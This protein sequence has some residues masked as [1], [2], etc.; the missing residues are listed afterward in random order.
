[1]SVALAM[2][3][4]IREGLRGVTVVRLRGPL[5]TYAGDM[6][7]A[8][9]RRRHGRRGAARARARAAR[10]EGL[11]PRRARPRAPAHRTVRQRR[12]RQRGARS[13]P[14]TASTSCRPSL[15]DRMTELLVGTKKGLFALRGRA[16]LAVRGGRAGVRRRAGRVRDARPAHGRGDRVGHLAVLRAEALGRRRRRRRVGAGR[17]GCRCPRAA[18]TRSS[19]SGRSCPAPTTQTLYAGGDPGVLFV[20]RD[21]G[22]VVGAAPAV[23]GAADAPGLAGR[24]AAGCACTRSRRG[25]AIPTAWRWRSPRSACG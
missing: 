19:A 13:G 18:T 7:R 3:F 20:S 15:E 6:R 17:A 8:P 14:T 10:R 21:G 25:P 5:K 4:R 16:G 23:L 2:S 12:V 22:D 9:G 1:M 11:D 24:A